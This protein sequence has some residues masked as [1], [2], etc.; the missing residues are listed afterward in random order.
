MDIYKNYF[1]SE[2]KKI[3][4]L[5]DPDKHTL[6]SAANI[7]QKIEKSTAN[8]IFV[9]GSMVSGSIMPIVETIKQNTKKPVIIFPGSISQLA[10]NADALLLL[11]L[12]S[13]R[14]PDYLIGNQVQAAFSIEK[15]GIEY[16]STAYILIDGGKRSSVEYVS[17]TIPIPGDKPDL[18][19]ATALAAKMI[20]MKAV[21]LEAGSG[22]INPVSE[23]IINAVKQNVKL[24]LIVGGGLRS[25]QSIEKAFNA[26]ADIAVVGTAVESGE[27]K[28]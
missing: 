6:T 12:V 9:G 5:I 22:A 24:P 17:N 21:Y 18:A 27:W 4:I 20:G 23:K 2:G 19:A 26:G 11:S 7:A 15:S 13:G 25:L 3:A 10:D 8:M 28:I 16:I 14:N 1:L